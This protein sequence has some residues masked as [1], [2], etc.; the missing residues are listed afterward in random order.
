MNDA[1]IVLLT[2]TSKVDL[3]NLTTGSIPSRL[4]T[5]ELDV[6]K[7]YRLYLNIL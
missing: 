3:A 6:F 5:P 7:L 1:I 4:L 2:V